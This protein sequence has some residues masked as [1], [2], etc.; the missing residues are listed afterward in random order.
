MISY[1]K[2]RPET[3][4][5]A[6]ADAP[7]LKRA[8]RRSKTPQFQLGSLAVFSPDILNASNQIGRFDT[9]DGLELDFRN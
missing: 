6:Q 5:Q 1:L 3:L 4:G 8:I 7:V 2:Y 9:S